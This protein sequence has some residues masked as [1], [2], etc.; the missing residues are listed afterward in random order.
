MEE[1]E[2]IAQEDIFYIIKLLCHMYIDVDKCGIPFDGMASHIITSFINKYYTPPVDMNNHHEMMENLR[3]YL[4]KCIK[5]STIR[6]IK[7]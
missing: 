7:T 1:E 3:H 2:N 6:E 5:N 4:Q